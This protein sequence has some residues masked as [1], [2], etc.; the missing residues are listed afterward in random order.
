MIDYEENVDRFK[1]IVPRILAFHLQV[2]VM[3]YLMTVIVILVIL[4]GSGFVYLP[5]RNSKGSADQASELSG[6]AGSGKC[7]NRANEGTNVTRIERDAEGGNWSD[8]F[9]DDHQVE[10]TENI[11]IGGEDDSRHLELDKM[12]T[13][14]WTQMNP[15]DKPPGR[16]SHDMA[17]DRQNDRIVLF[18]GKDAQYRYRDTWTYDVNRDRWDHLNPNPRPESRRAP[19]MTYDDHNNKVVLFGG[20][21]THNYRDD[22]WIYDTATNSWVN[23]T[24]SSS[25]PGRYYHRTVYDSFNRKVVLFGGYSDTNN[26]VT[27]YHDTW[28]YDGATNTW[29]QKFPNNP[30]QGRGRFGMAYDSID[31]KVI[32]FGGN[33][34]NNKLGDTWVYDVAM[35]T[36]TQ[37]F[38][39]VSPS[40]RS[41]CYMVY[42][43]F[44]GKTVL[45]GGYDDN[46][47][48]LDDT[49]TYCIV[50]NMWTRM[51]NNPRPFTRAVHS[52]VY[53]EATN[54]V[55][56]FGGLSLGPTYYDDT[57][58]YRLESRNTE[59]YCVSEPIS[60]PSGNLWN[61]LSL[62]KTE[63]KDTSLKISII[64]ANNNHTITGFIGL[65]TKDIDLAGLNERDIRKI[66]LKAEFQGNSIDGPSLYSWNVSWT[67]IEAP[68]LVGEIDDIPIMEDTPENDILT[69]SE[70]FNDIYSHIQAP[71]YAIEYM[72]DIENIT[73]EVDNAEL[74]VVRLA[75]NWSGDISM[76]V[77]CTNRY[78]YSTSSDVFKITVTDVD[79]PPA[80]TSDPPAITMNEDF[81]YVTTYSLREFVIDAE[82]DEVDFFISGEDGN[83]SANLTETGH[84]SVLPAEDFNGLSNLTVYGMERDDNEI[85]TGSIS[86]P[87]IVKP[88]ND[89]PLVELISPTSGEI[90]GSSNVTF[91]WKAHD[92][93]NDPGDLSFVLYLDKG[94]SPSI[95]T[96][97]LHTNVFT[98]SGLEN[99]ATYYWYI[100]PFDGEEFGRCQSGTWN[101]TIDIEVPIPK[102]TLGSP[103]ANVTLK[104]SEVELAW[105]IIDCPGEDITYHVFLGD[106][107]YDLVDIG[108]TQDVHYQLSDLEDN[109]TYYWKVTGE[110]EGIPTVFESEIWHFTVQLGFVPIHRIEMGFDTPL[111]SVKRR[112]SVIVG[113]TLR[114]LGNVAEMINI[115]VLGDLKDHV[116]TNNTVE[117]GIGEEKTINVK[118]FAESK[119]ELKTYPLTVEAVFSRERTTANMNVKVTE[120]SKMDEENK[121]LMSWLW[122]FIG[123]ILILAIASLLIFIILQKRKRTNDEG[124]VIA[125]EIEAHAPTGITQTDLELLS[126]N[127]TEQWGAAPFQGRFAEM[128][129]QYTLPSQQTYQHKPLASFVTLPEIKATGAV[130]EEP[131]AL[132]QT[133]SGLPVVAARPVPV[134]SQPK[135]QETGVG[136]AKVHAVPMKSA[137][138][139]TAILTRLIPTSPLPP[140]TAES[141]DHPV[142]PDTPDAPSIPSLATELFPE[143][144]KTSS[145][146][147]PPPPS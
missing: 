67:A 52:L 103:E 53:D 48:F 81:T 114:N 11:V 128:P 116:S 107:V 14:Q 33:D 111:V 15:P 121:G 118:I 126:F 96:S 62:D 30:P 17:Y 123:A 8:D 6:D 2:K 40:R 112:D 89:P 135:A 39:A 45:F 120:E 56:C 104:T 101:F 64:D 129:L 82:A 119:L 9:E 29:T 144:L 146:L 84:I 141:A 47:D 23:M 16:F 108:S 147:P 5:E 25:P 143:A 139:K 65:D 74:D 34:G 36:W 133:T 72:S 22:T 20:W 63:E 66:R 142:S 85:R 131:K 54:Q 21:D 51:F 130:K 100:I 60:L 4:T 43:P 58:T 13:N 37:V 87:V 35:N 99:G 105:D 137:V 145:E 127:G 94:S 28:V 76:I 68:E 50:T 83:I 124:E 32:L 57:W 122:F 77:N 26:I 55:V 3:K 75:N 95:Y 38:P 79:D 10:W 86:I 61:A 117:L 27:Y 113:L 12:E 102:V 88:V 19:A 138:R 140:P 7:K 31:H 134:V 106:N 73:L 44:A 24:P 59:G 98:I 125:A 18:G 110:A 71:A 115:D 1:S 91:S 70:C 109:H 78:G 93:D 41:D 90:L 132:P 80:W 92:I 136:I 49:W 69:L 46:I 42:D 97:D